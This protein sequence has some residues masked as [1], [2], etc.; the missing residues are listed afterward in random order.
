MQRDSIG[1]PRMR[2]VRGLTAPPRRSGGPRPRG[3]GASP[4]ATSRTGAEGEP[5][6]RSSLRDRDSRSRAEAGGISNSTDFPTG[7]RCP[8]TLR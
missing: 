1:R 3:E 5:R 4:N 2:G 7:H 6:S 8:T